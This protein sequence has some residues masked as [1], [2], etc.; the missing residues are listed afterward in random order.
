MIHW[1][2]PLHSVG[3]TGPSLGYYW[4]LDKNGKVAYAAKP[5]DSSEGSV[6]FKDSGHLSL[7]L[8]AW[9]E[10]ERAFDD[11]KV[12]AI[13]VCNMP[14]DLLN[15]LF[16]SARI[17]PH[18]HQFEAHPQLPQVDLLQY[19]LTHA[20]APMAHS[21]LGG[22]GGGFSALASDPA[23]RAAVAAASTQRSSGGE[24]SLAQLLVE[25]A[26]HRNCGGV[27]S[28]GSG[29]HVRELFE[30]GVRPRASV[31]ALGL[32]GDVPHSRHHRRHAPSPF[33]FLFE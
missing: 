7:L 27:I 24:A 33:A 9:Q 11:G 22:G 14:L 28:S 4:P 30:A 6:G 1:P 10:L 18:V 2:V 26:L 17:K 8:H 20:I 12:R 16:V 13:G 3:V 23:S 29:Q 21:A 15:E 5:A 32:L 31:D 25:W 19:C